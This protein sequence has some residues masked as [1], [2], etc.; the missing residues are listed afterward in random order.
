V[1]I[2]NR[3]Q[4]LTILTLTAI[5][6]LVL[7]KIV[8][9]PLTSFWNTRSARIVALKNQVKDGESLKRNKEFF[10]RHWA[11][12]KAGALTNDTTAAELQLGTGLNH[13]AQMSGIQIDS[14]ALQW[15]QGTDASYKTLDCR[16]DASGSIDRLSRFMYELE[17]DPMDLKVQSVEMTSKDNSWTV[18]GLGVQISG[19]ILTGLEPKK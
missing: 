15:K 5:G 1:Q 14:T 3:Q 11:D 10:R 9:P 2:K 7:D 6:L 8:T 13:W 12:I 19:L 16:V 17:T 18:I 4:F